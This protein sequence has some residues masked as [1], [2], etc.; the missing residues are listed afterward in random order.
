MNYYKN[1]TI[2]LFFINTLLFNLSTINCA[3]K[4]SKQARSILSS[5][6][7]TEQLQTY[8][9]ANC[10]DN[11]LI[12]F[13]LLYPDVPNTKEANTLFKQELNR[14]K[15]W[16]HEGGMSPKETFTATQLHIQ[17]VL[18]QK[19][20][21]VEKSCY[22]LQQLIA[23]IPDHIKHDANSIDYKKCFSILNFTV[24]AA[25]KAQLRENNFNRAATLINLVSDDIISKKTPDIPEDDLALYTDQALNASFQL[26]AALQSEDVSERKKMNDAAIVKDIYRS[27]QPRFIKTVRR[28]FN[29]LTKS[30]NDN[31]KQPSENPTPP[32]QNESS[33]Q[34]QDIPSTQQ[35]NPPVLVAQTAPEII[36][37]KKRLEE[38]YNKI[39]NHIRTKLNKDNDWQLTRSEVDF[40][41]HYKPVLTALEITRFRITKKQLPLKGEGSADEHPT[42]VVSSPTPSSATSGAENQAPSMPDKSKKKNGL[43]QSDARYFFP[44]R[45]D[46]SSEDRQIAL[47]ISR[48]I[49]ERP[50]E[51][52]EP[53]PSK[54]QLQKKQRRI[55][56]KQRAIFPQNQDPNRMDPYANN[57][58]VY[59]EE[60]SASTK[61]TFAVG[62]LPSF[63]HV[64]NPSQ[65]ELFKPFNNNPLD[66][67]GAD[68]H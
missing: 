53:Q 64:Q 45:V 5:L 23:M 68:F 41:E 8:S 60:E 37:E 13:S 17:R 54:K 14:L 30:V 34:S 9:Y 33:G 63:L 58:P 56:K 1:N 10:V 20:N 47:E 21:D 51:E 50:L 43:D 22:Y 12:K 15:K 42:T 59:V 65:F 44:K 39:L 55:L 24:I 2:T 11:Y 48:L 32:Q 31:E 4:L 38:E 6:K 62:S 49:R 18:A 27:F 67:I 19:N 46:S 35:N 16:F 29:T 28:Q 40:I 7:L 3:H 25:C 26:L 52:F 66:N 61:T 57:D 36:Q